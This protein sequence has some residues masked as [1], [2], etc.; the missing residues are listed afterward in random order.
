MTASSTSSTNNVN[1]ANPKVSTVSTN[2][3]TTSTENSTA[4]PSDAIIYAFLANQPKWS[5]LVHEDLEQIH[6]DD[7]E[8]MDLK[9]RLALLSMRARKLYQRTGMKI[10]ING[11]DTAGFDKSKVECFNCHKMGHFA[12]ECRVPRNKDGQYR[13]QDNSR[14]QESS[15]RIMNVEDTSLKEML[16]IDGIGFD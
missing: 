2:A 5:Q 13:Y 6:D 3:N 16:A 7:L 8:E 15:K 9:W 14:N 11:S 12:R 10:T 4:N 1:T